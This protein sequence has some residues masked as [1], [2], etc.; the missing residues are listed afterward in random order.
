MIAV[1]IPPPSIANPKD[2]D[3]NHGAGIVDKPKSIQRIPRENSNIATAKIYRRSFGPFRRSLPTAPVSSLI[4][5]SSPGA[6]DKFQNA[7][8]GYTIAMKNT[9]HTGTP[10]HGE[11]AP[12]VILIIKQAAI[13][14]VS[15][16]RIGFGVIC[17]ASLRRAGTVLL[18]KSDVRP[19]TAAISI[20]PNRKLSPPISRGY[21]R[22]LGID[23]ATDVSTKTP[24]RMEA[25]DTKRDEVI[26][27][28]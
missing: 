16:N 20:K 2:S 9:A 11:T 24:N 25:K 26:Q 17:S 7:I 27:T 15:K 13:A 14:T 6:M 12:I 19:K 3:I 5:I 8:P 28:K 10:I 4:P 23:R 21:E 1:I 22:A 18:G